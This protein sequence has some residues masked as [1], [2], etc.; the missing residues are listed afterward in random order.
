MN[1]LDILDIYAMENDSDDIF[2]LLQD[3]TL[4]NRITREVMN[5]V[6]LKD[7]GACRPITTDCD[8]FKILLESFFNKYNYNISKL[9]DTMYYEYNPLHNKD[10]Q[11]KLN[12]DEHRH[13]IGDI[14][15]TDTYNTNTDQTNT[16][17]DSNEKTVS[18]YDSP[19]YQ[20]K[21]RDTE[22]QNLRT[23]ND[24]HHE[25]ETTS[26]IE[27]TVDTDRHIGEKIEGKDGEASYQTLI[28]QERKLAE[29]NIFNWIVNQMRNELFLLIY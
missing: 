20:P 5:T 27:S 10:L 6:I 18:A 15:N 9:L 19:N 14:D 1:L 16:G 28:E 7:L 2:L 4:D 21:E 8:L 22:T 12:E 25:G 26:D 24:V 23:D 13:S 3:Y 29:F 17:T 11:R